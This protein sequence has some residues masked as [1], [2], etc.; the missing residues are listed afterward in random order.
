MLSCSSSSG[1]EIT[2]QSG[3]TVDFH[4]LG[5]SSKELFTGCVINLNLSAKD[6]NNGKMIFSSNNHGL[7]GVSS[8]YYDSTIMIS[9]L[10]EVF[11]QIFVGDSFSIV[12]KS[13]LFFN[14]FFGDNFSN[15]KQIDSYP[16]SLFLN[17]KVL[18]YN[19]LKEQKYINSKLSLSAISSENKLLTQIKNDWE[20]RF[21]NI[22]KKEGLY[23]VKLG[24]NENVLLSTDVNNQFVSLNYTIVDLNGR[25]LY[26]TNSKDEY[27]DKSLNGQLLDG[28][29][30]LV[31]QYERG[32]SIV[33]LIPSKLLFGQRGSFVNKI[34]PYTPAQVNLRIN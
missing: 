12:M 26:T 16:D 8:F 23:S 13:S 22:F 32:D 33:A 3:F 18:G 19:T 17:V 30:I 2:T 15:D 20:N 28:F 4:E 5:T 11:S 27:Y 10:D 14:S 6:N 29:N 34:P 24:S 21:L 9:P 31:S 1:G 7:S 25:L